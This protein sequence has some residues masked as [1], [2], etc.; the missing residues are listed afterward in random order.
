MSEASYRDDAYG[1]YKGAHNLVDCQNPR[2][3]QR[4]HA[5]DCGECCD[6]CWFMCCASRRAIN[7]H[8]EALLAS[9]TSVS[10]CGSVTLKDLDD[11]IHDREDEDDE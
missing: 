4:D 8:L 7:T 11:V 3:F 6:A 5:C 1:C 10:N 2:C 9:M